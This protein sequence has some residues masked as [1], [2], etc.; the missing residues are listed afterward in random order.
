[1]IRVLIADDHQLL[2]EGLAQALNRLPDITVVGTAQD[3]K[4]LVEL[5]GDVPADVV[6]LDQDMP[7]LTGIGAI[8]RLG[9]GTQAIVVTMHADEEHRAKA[10]R[11]GAVG[12]LSKSAPLPLLAAAVRAAAA[13]ETFVEHVGGS[14][15]LDSY[16]EA[17]LDPGAAALTKRERELLSLLARGV[18]STEE[19][20]EQLFISPKTVKNHLASIYDKLAVS[21]RAQAAVEAIRLGL[22]R[23]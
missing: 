10:E 17:Q 4:E 5:A 3:G 12:F 6:I 7:K 1:M 22:A 18:S 11:A 2:L 14:E 16:H 15:I 8:K 20:A 21:D 23:D 13:G 9:S 19:L